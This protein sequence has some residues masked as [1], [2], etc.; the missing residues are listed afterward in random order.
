MKKQSIII[1]SI[2]LL[3]V[4]NTFSQNMTGDRILGIW[5]NEDKDAKVEIYKSGNQY[6]GKLI[7]GKEMYEADG[8]TSRK[9][10]ENKDPKLR[11]RNL[12]DLIMLS[13]FAYHDD[14]WDGGEI[15]DPRN[16][17]TYSCTLKLKGS[18]LDIRGYIGISLF[19]KTTVWEHIQ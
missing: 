14:V 15:Y 8:K 16:G 17:S 6:F 7:W 19:G 18:K 2:L 3:A 4:V 11:A 10:V 9:D 1:I 12:K 13:G 5:L